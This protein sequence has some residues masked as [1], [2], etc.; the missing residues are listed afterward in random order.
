MTDFVNIVPEVKAA[1][2]LVLASTNLREL[3]QIGEYIK[4]ADNRILSKGTGFCVD[5]TGP[6]VTASHVIPDDAS[7]VQIRFAAALEVPYPATLRARDKDADI[8]VLDINIRVPQ[9]PYA[10]LG[11]FNECREGEEIGFIGFPLQFS[12]PITHR[13]IISGKTHLAYEQG[14]KAVPVLTVNAFVNRGNSGGPVFRADSGEILAVVNAKPNLPNENMFLRLPPNYS[15]IMTLG[16]VDPLA[17]T[18][19]TYNRTIKHI[20]EVTQIG[21]AFCTSIDLVKALL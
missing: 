18:V 3:P 16:G 7:G 15:P 1:T 12:F 11:A 2:V 13:G 9:L 21:V 17:L 10:R 14:L 8:C 6:V 19:E 5:P 20:G 4:T